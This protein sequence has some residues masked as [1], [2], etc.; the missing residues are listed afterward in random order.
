MTSNLPNPEK[1]KAIPLNFATIV[2]G[3]L[4]ILPG[5]VDLIFSF[6]KKL[7]IFEDDSSGFTS[8]ATDQFG[9]FYVY[10]PFWEEHVTNME[11]LVF[12]LYHEMFHHICVDVIMYL[13]DPDLS[14]NELKLR[15]IRQVADNFAMDSRINSYLYRKYRLDSTFVCNFYDNLVNSTKDSLFKLLKP[16]SE[17]SK[18]HEEEVKVMDFYNNYYTEDKLQSHYALS[19]VIFQILLDRKNE[20]EE[21]LDNLLKELLGKHSDDSLTKEDIEKLIKEGKVTVELSP[22]SNEEGESSSDSLNNILDEIIPSRGSGKGDTLTVSILETK[23]DVTEK[24]NINLFKK[25]AFD[26]IFHN[27]RTQARVKTAKYTTSPIIP[28]NIAKTDALLLAEDVDVLLWKSKKYEYKTDPKLLPIYL[29][30]SGSTYSYLP[31]IIKLIANV[32]KDLDYVWG[33]SNKVV[34]HTIEMLTEN[35]INSTGG[36]DFDCII[37]HALENKYNHIVVITD[38][39]GSTGYKYNDIKDSI[40]SVVTILFGYSAKNN[41]FT[42]NYKNTFDI[43]E[44]KI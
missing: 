35:K 11:T 5:K 22:E 18:N 10:R 39:D 36:T 17:F 2:D 6:I 37:S 29:D 9:N 15:K 33:F 27:V 3:Y 23:S 4:A 44:V 14:K 25:M 16:N 32:S 42:K 28:V 20:S 1:P 13:P 31:E 24:L 30:V 19:D 43:S 41:F 8:I 34:K 21:S 26:N 38:G 7:I 40:N 12:L